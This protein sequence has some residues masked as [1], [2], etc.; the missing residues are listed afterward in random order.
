MT[1]TLQR[2]LFG[3]IA[4]L[5]ATATFEVSGAFAQTQI[6]DG[7]VT[8]TICGP[9]TM[10]VCGK[11]PIKVCDR[12][13]QL[14]LNPFTR[15]FGWS[16]VETNCSVGGY[17]NLYKDVQTKICTPGTGSGVTRRGDEEE[18]DDSGFCD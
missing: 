15:Q 10:V 7:D 6:G 4:I 3:A 12:Q 2:T 9:G 5:V 8:S 17:K 13:I 11:E 1:Y 14:I 16:W 18:G